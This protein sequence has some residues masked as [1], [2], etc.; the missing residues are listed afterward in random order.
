L[1]KL[2]R[3]GIWELRVGL[4]QRALFRLSGDEATFVFLGAHDE[5]KRFLK[6]LS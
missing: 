6:T 5:V 3:T 2:H 4:S 1:R